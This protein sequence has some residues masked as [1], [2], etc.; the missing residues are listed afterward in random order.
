MADDGDERGRRDGTGSELRG[1]A[2]VTVV[3]VTRVAAILQENLPALFRV[4][5]GSSR[6]GD[7]RHGGS[8]DS[9]ADGHRNLA[10]LG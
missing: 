3:A 1:D 10:L 9:G 4:A 5:L 2:A 8:S 7:L 6:V